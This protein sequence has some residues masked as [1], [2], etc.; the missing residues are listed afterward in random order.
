MI[1]YDS[2]YKLIEDKGQA[3]IILQDK[4]CVFVFAL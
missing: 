1:Y 3:Y 2:I 4:L